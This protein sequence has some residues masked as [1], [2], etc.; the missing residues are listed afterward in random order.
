V[1]DQLV[2]KGHREVPSNWVEA[3]PDREGGQSIDHEAGID[4]VGTGGLT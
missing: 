2:Q 4:F 3:S 1:L